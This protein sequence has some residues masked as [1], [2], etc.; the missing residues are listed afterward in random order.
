MGK[1]RCICGNIISDVCEP[2]ELLGFLYSSWDE[3]L[4]EDSDYRT[5]WECDKCGTL[6]IEHPLETNLI[7]FYVP[8]DKIIGNLFKRTD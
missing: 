1:F 8:E 3:N 5:V 7:K 6:A 4:S 2:D